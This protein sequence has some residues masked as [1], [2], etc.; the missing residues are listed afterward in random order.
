METKIDDVLKLIFSLFSMFDWR[1][2]MAFMTCNMGPHSEQYGLP[3]F[4]AGYMKGLIAAY[5]IATYLQKPSCTFSIDTIATGSDIP[6]F[7]SAHTQAG[8]NFSL[9]VMFK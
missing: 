7:P 9:Y 3:R 6:E 8:E 5:N 2:A 1:S 4:A